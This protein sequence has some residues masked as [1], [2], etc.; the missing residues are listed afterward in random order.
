VS[1]KNIARK[2][3]S[4]PMFTLGISDKIGNIVLAAGVSQAVAIPA[5]AISAIFTATGDFWVDVRDAN[6]AVV[7]TGAEATNGLLLNPVSREV[8]ELLAA[9]ITNLYMISTA[10]CLVSIE[11]CGE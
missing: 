5:D 6:P 8:S 4:H 11:W 10:G 9:G 2:E 7:P 3:K 1:I